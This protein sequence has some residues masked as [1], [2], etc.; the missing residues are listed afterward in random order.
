[1]KREKIGHKPMYDEP[2]LFNLAQVGMVILSSKSIVLKINP[3]A[4]QFFGGTREII[5][6]SFKELIYHEAVFDPKT[7]YQNALDK[8]QSQT[9]VIRF[10]S[11]DEEPLWGIVSFVMYGNN[12]N[13]KLV[14]CQIKNISELKN[15]INEINHQSIILMEL[16]NNIPDNIF[17]KDTES[18]FMMAN[19][20]VSQLMGAQSPN[21]LIGKTDFDFFPLKLAQRY[22][23]DEL[24]VITSGEAKL[25]IIEQV[26]SKKRIHRW[27]STSK[28]P[29]K[30]SEGQIIGIMGIGRDITQW[31]RKQKELKKAKLSAEKAN[32]LKSAFLANLSHE[33]RTPLNGILG[34]SQF[35]RQLIE[36]GTKGYQY[37]DFIIQNGK[38]LLYL[39]SDIIDISKIDSGQ[40]ILSKKKFILNEPLRQ[41]EV[42]IREILVAKDKG[43]IELKL[44]LPLSD[45]VSIVYSDD[46]R[47]KQ[48]LYYLLANAV[49]FTHQG[50]I[51][52]GYTVEQESI[53]FYVRD[54]GIGIA[55][56]SLA[57]IFERFAQ[58]DS[59]ITRQY[60]GT[61]IGLSIAKGLI[62]LLGG[63]IGVISEISK[64]SEFFFMLPI[65]GMY[66]SIE[67][68]V[69][70][71]ASSTAKQILFV[72]A[73]NSLDEKVLTSLRK[74]ANLIHASTISEL[75]KKLKSALRPPDLILC[76]PDISREVAP[77][78]INQINDMIPQVPI[79]VITSNNRSLIIEECLAAGAKD[80]IAEPINTDL[81]A[82]KI[83]Q[84]T[85]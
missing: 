2:E 35:L 27:Y 43:N 8:S 14:L 67:K 24:E 74:N 62:Q 73:N 77:D 70:P 81:M 31:V 46:H 49:K 84:L 65:A 18:R 4:K 37:I 9:Y 52:F 59:S 3:E 76:Y 69:N 34:F 17:I 23:Q 42:S 80:F 71:I 44:E 48:I 78:L 45:E 39:I 58:A 56:E 26:I 10:K 21:E 22:R 83:K 55:K 40:L 30:N 11:I 64:G 68:E 5:G 29:L 53:R 25:N 54:T 47:I 60:E 61:G 28:I 66:K 85:R 6:L 51:T 36:P 20:W 33:V 15:A 19:V 12:K 41:L 38:Q 32:Q 82:E 75:Y 1:M 7:W 50:T 16:I 57:I 79:L 63:E 13:E 72:G